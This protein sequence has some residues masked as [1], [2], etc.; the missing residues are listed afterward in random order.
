MAVLMGAG[1]YRSKAIS[2][3]LVDRRQAELVESGI[4]PRDARRKAISELSAKVKAQQDAI[5]KQG[6]LNLGVDDLPLFTKTNETTAAY[7]GI[8][9]AKSAVEGEA[10]RLEEIKGQLLL[11]L[12]GHPRALRGRWKTTIP[13]RFRKSKYVDMRGLLWLWL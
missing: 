10:K 1:A 3:Q 13:A 6:A 9:E 8:D 4:N 11:P 2:Y 12:R 7:G 5:M